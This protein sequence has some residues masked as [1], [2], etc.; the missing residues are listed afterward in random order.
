MA[1]PRRQVERISPEL[2][3]QPL[4][5]WDLGDLYA[6]PDSPEIEAD[7]E[8]A[9]TVAT[10]LADEFKGR[11]GEL[12][13]DALGELIA[14]YEQLEEWLGRAMSY[15]QLLHAANTEDPKIGRF[16]QTVQERVNE[17]GTQVL[18]VTLEL[19]RI[20][21]DALEA[22]SRLRPGLPI[23]GRGSATCAASARTSWTTRSSGCCTRRR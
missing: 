14:R 21:E 22:S 17:I 2:V 7:L 13:G 9:A 4:P 23:T 18:F 12:D 10:A 19:N 1:R 5:T 16:F 6:A 11:L 20:E 15:A 8:R 3:E